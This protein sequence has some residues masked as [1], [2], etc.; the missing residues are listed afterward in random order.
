[1]P[2]VNGTTIPEGVEQLRPR[3]TQI[4][5]SHIEKSKGVRCSLFL[6]GI[7]S[8]LPLCNSKAYRDD[9]RTP[10]QA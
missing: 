6:S 1:M 9:E 4:G 3:R 10:L 2:I 5:I 8:G 7:G